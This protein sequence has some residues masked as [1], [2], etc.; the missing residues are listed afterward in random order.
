MATFSEFRRLFKKETLLGRPASKPFARIG[1]FGDLRAAN[2][3]AS[4]KTDLFLIYTIA[5]IAAY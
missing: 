4:I 2:P 1:L 3:L 5:E